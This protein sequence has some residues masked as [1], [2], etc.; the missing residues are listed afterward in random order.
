MK[1]SDFQKRDLE[2]QREFL[3]RNGKVEGINA[4]SDYISSV[5]RFSYQTRFG[6]Q[7]RQNTEELKMAQAV[8]RRRRQW[9]K[10]HKFK[11]NTILRKSGE[12]ASDIPKEVSNVEGLDE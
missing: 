2:F 12:S 4:P 7:G 3:E 8:E 9:R 10:K 11:P 6:R 1:L 5:I